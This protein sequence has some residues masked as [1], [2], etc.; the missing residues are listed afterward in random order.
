VNGSRLLAVRVSACPA[1]GY[2]GWAAVDE[3]TDD[4]RRVLRGTPVERRRQRREGLP[5]SG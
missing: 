3:L 1:C 2:L 5:A 4:E